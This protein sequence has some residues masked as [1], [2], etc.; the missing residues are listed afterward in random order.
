MISIERV[1]VGNDSTRISQ[2]WYNLDVVLTDDFPA[3]ER[4]D[5]VPPMARLPP[6]CPSASLFVNC[7]FLVPGNLSLPGHFR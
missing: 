4:D 3:F 1:A 7:R 5:R 6:S 2:T